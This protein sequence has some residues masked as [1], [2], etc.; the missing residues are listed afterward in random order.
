MDLVK[1]F[2]ELFRGLERAHGSYDIKD[3]KS[4]GK[5]SGLAQTLNEP[6]TDELWKDHLKGK[7]GLG[8]IPIN[9]EAECYWG[10][11][12]I[13]KYDLD[14]PKEIKK[15]N[16]K[17][18]PLIP[19]RTKSGGLH[20]FLFCKTPIPA[21][22]MQE[23]LTEM[24][25]GCGFGGCEIFPKQIKLLVE[26][27]DVGSWLN[28][29]Y[30]NGSQTTRYGLDSKGKAISP[31]KFIELTKSLKQTEKQVR[32]IKHQ[33]NSFLPEGPP[34][35]QH[36]AVSGFPEGTRNDGLFNL[37]VYSR[38]AFPDNWEE[39]VEEL[40][41]EHMNPPLK[42][43]EVLTVIKS[44]RRKDY[45]YTCNRAPIAPHCNAMVCRQR[46]HGIGASGKG[47][48]NLGSLTK[49]NTR[50]PIWFI[51]V[52]SER[53][54]LQTDDLQNQNRFQRRCM[55]QLNSM[56][57]IVNRNNWQQLI[58]HLLSNVNIVEVP[59][60]AS[61]AGQFWEM[62]ESFC[63][64]RVQAQSREEILIGKPWSDEGRTYFRVNDLL[65]FLDRQ[66]FR[67]FKVHQIYAILR[68]KG[69]KHHFFNVKGK[70]INAWSITEFNQQNEE[71]DSPNFGDDSII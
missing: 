51:D 10:A 50:P 14:I 22:L 47:M 17:G 37:G 5:M 30:F 63:T 18:Y 12:D 59:E 71:F 56:P 48:P 44:L 57:S 20:L 39:S 40:N 52:E 11:A 43:S 27:G 25:A 33:E 21:R 67:D 54:E 16:E 7:K 15:I 3:Q 26:R 31:K 70:G 19:C 24:A 62:V 34:C 29:P 42:S 64:G 60:D 13:D 53:L 55:E 35:L 65:A 36:L 32:S 49:L 23:K 68:D 66:H 58:Q 9:D 1:E 61:A 28:M 41:R 6:V 38:K 8:I 69:A 45:E 4:S 2:S 46:K